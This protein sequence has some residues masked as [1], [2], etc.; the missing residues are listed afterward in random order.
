ML[1]RAGF[2]KQVVSDP[3]GMLERHT[4]QR[5]P[6]ELKIFIH[7]EDANALHFSIPPSPANVNELSGGGALH[8]KVSEK[9]IRIDKNMKTVV[10]PYWR[11]TNKGLA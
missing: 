2:K 5:L 8:V 9:P 7:E 10:C 3:K 4:G 11:R 1:E 6:S